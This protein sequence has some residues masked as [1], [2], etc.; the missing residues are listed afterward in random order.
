MKNY[1]AEFCRLLLFVCLQNAVAQPVNLGLPPVTH[2][3]KTLY[4]AGTQS[5]D[6]GQDA[7]GLVYLANN[8]GL[9]CFNGDSWHCY[10]I[11]NGT[12]V[13]SLHIDSTDSRIYVGGQGELGY[14][15]PDASGKLV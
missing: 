10:P 3:A 4:Q 1:K 7:R 2:Y 8:E 11:S 15:S 5:W 14:F 13:R 12:C 9:L 6:I